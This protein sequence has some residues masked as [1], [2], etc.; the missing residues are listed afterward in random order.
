MIRAGRREKGGH[1]NVAHL[2]FEIICA[3]Q[4]EKEGNGI[5]FED[6]FLAILRAL[7]LR[8]TAKKTEWRKSNTMQ[9]YSSSKRSHLKSGC[10]TLPPFSRGPAHISLTNEIT[11]SRRQLQYGQVESGIEVGWR[12]SVVKGT[13][14]SSALVRPDTVQWQQQRAFD[15]PVGFFQGAV[16]HWVLIWHGAVVEQPGKSRPWIGL[17]E[18]CQRHVCAG[19]NS[20]RECDLLLCWNVHGDAEETQ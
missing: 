14:I 9:S 7:T 15:F 19:V 2:V 20:D 5:F 1:S 17:R 6:D 12:Q 16:N 11:V 13:L 8:S 10:A 3:S 4:W 18:A